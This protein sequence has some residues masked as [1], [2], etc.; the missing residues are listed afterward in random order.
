MSPSLPR[1]THFSASLTGNVFVGVLNTWVRWKCHQIFDKYKAIVASIRLYL[2]TYET[3]K[4]NE[5]QFEEAAAG[6]RGLLV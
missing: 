2:H 6:P 3:K 5:D 4:I 1:R